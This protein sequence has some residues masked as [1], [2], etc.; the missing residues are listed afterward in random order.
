M[1]LWRAQLDEIRQ[2]LRLTIRELITEED[3]KVRLEEARSEWVPIEELAE[4]LTEDYEAWQD[5]DFQELE[6]G[7]RAIM[8]EAWERVR[9]DKEHWL[10]GHVKEG[11]LPGRGKGQHL[12]VVM[13]A[14]DDLVGL[15]TDA[16]PED[17]LSYRVLPDSKANEVAQERSDLRRLQGVLDGR[18]FYADPD[19]A[20]PTMPTSHI[21][22][23]RDSTVHQ[24]VSCRVQLRAVDFF[25]E[26]MAAEF[27]SRHFA[28]S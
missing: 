5:A 7:G 13:G 18:P 8:D 12:K 3:Y 19:A 11:N 16:F 27:S 15:Q 20:S 17:Y 28:R 24:A 22:A 14:F 6:D 10:R 9:A 4:L 21:E 2:A 25:L 23:L 26:E 1:T